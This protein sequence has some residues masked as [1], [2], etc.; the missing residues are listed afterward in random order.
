MFKEVEDLPVTITKYGIPA[1]VVTNVDTEDK[2]VIT[3][4]E[5]HDAYEKAVAPVKE[6]EI[7]EWVNEQCRAFEGGKRCKELATASG[8][9]WND[10]SGDTEDVPMCKTHAF[11]SLKEVLG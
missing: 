1:Y 3:A 10:V 2:P 7:P 6:V 8:K 9:A 4:K 11:K 5:I